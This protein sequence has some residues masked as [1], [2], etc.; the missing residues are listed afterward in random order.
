MAQV[1]IRDPEIM[2]GTPVFLGTRVP[3][4]TLF[5]YLE[6]GETLED[7]LTGFRTVSRDAALKALEEAKD[8][9]LSKTRCECCST[10]VLTNALLSAAEAAGFAAIITVD[11]EIPY[12]QGMESRKIAVLILCAATNRLR[13]LQKLGSVNSAL[14]CIRSDPRESRGWASDSQLHERSLCA[15]VHDSGRRRAPGL[16]DQSRDRIAPF[17]SSCLQSLVALRM[18]VPRASGVNGSPRRTMMLGLDAR[19][20]ASIWG[21]IEIVRH[22]HKS[23]VASIFANFTVGGS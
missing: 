5:D 20:C 1:I 12:Q 11:Q 4:Q 15:S 22:D 8:L 19:V 16:E 17:L 6:G 23:R 14:D 9:L 13:N 7:F 21:E 2:R 10:S 3:V 18:A